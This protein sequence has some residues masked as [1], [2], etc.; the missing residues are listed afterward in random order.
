MDDE[1]QL[2]VTPDGRRWRWHIEI[3]RFEVNMA[4]FARYE[5]VPIVQ[6][7]R[8]NDAHQPG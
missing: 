4:E 7:R 8:G 6:E 1:R 5:I 2:I 3:T